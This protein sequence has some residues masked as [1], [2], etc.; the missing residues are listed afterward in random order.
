V[1]PR[2]TSTAMLTKVTFWRLQSDGV[3]FAS[4]A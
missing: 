2:M 1:R 4:L 3:L